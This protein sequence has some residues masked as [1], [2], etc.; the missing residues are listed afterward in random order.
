[1]AEDAAYNNDMPGILTAMKG[2]SLTGRALVGTPENNYPAA[3]LRGMNA[4]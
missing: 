2:N 4:A 3:T 1:M